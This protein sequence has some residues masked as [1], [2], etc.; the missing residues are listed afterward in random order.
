MVM[1]LLYPVAVRDSLD[2]QGRVELVYF[3]LI[4]DRAEHDVPRPHTHADVD[5][6]LDFGRFVPLEDETEV[7]HLIPVFQSGRC[8]LERAQ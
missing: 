7:H 3:R 6:K 4:V 2:R 8:R 1:A 5:E